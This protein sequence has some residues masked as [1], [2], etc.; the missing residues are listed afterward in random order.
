MTFRAVPLLFGAHVATL[1]QVPLFTTAVRFWSDAQLCPPIKADQTEAAIPR[2]L[3]TLG[4]LLSLSTC[5]LKGSPAQLLRDLGIAQLCDRR[6]RERPS[7]GRCTH[8][9]LLRWCW[10]ATKHSR[11]ANLVSFSHAPNCATRMKNGHES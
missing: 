11:H 7:L 6:I 3:L 2:A 1:A 9:Q 8:A 4:T 5:L 10:G